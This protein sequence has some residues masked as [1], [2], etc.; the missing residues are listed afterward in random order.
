MA[1]NISK[2]DIVN[3][4]FYVTRKIEAL[5]AILTDTQ[6]LFGHYLEFTDKE[7]KFLEYLDKIKEEAEQEKKKGEKESKTEEKEKPQENLSEE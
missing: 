4:V 2:N 5:E 3:Q 1:K 6:A 7:E